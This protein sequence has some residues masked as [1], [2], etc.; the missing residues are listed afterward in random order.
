MKFNTIDAVIERELDTAVQLNLIFVRIS[1][2]CFGYM[3]FS[4]SCKSCV[5]VAVT[6]LLTF[7]DLWV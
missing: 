4:T 3:I 5:V 6:N 1:I 2:R 7:L